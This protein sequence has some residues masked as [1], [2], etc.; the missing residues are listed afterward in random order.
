MSQ[1][2][3]SKSGVGPTYMPSPA[4]SPLPCPPTDPASDE[5]VSGENTSGEYVSSE[6][7]TGQ[8]TAG[9]MLPQVYERLRRFAKQRFS[10]NDSITG[11]ELVHEAYLRLASSDTHWD[12]QGHFLAAFRTAMRNV[13]VDHIRR[14]TTLKRGG[15]YHQ[16]TGIDVD[17]VS[18]G[19]GDHADTFLPRVVELADALDRLESQD[20]RAA[21]V[22]TMRFFGCMTE[23]EIAADLNLSVR[24]VSRNWIYARAWLRDSMNS[25]DPLQDGDMS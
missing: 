2:H 1:S 10:V 14:K 7:V 23:A 16:N 25:D 17:S 11:T 20:A 6:P 22:V 5:Y 21:A 3:S 4:P 18:S 24:T 19:V 15:A 12:N 8:R 13:I 9:A